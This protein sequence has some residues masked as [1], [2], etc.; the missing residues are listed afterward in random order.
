MAIELRVVDDEEGMLAALALWNGVYTPLAVSRADLADYVDYCEARFDVLALVD[1]R[2]V[3]SAFAAIEPDQ[4]ADV[5][6]SHVAVLVDARCQGAGTLLYR[7]VSGWVRGRGRTQ[8]QSIV[9]DADPDGAEW[10]RARGFVEVSRE[11]AVALQLRDAE[12]AVVP[13]DGVAIVT[14]AERPELARGMYEVVCEAMPDIPGEDDAVPAY[15]VWLRSYMGGASDRPEA[16]FVA[17]AGEEVVGFAKL[18]LSEARP[19]VAVHDLTGVRRAWR[20]RG[21]ARALKAT[22]IRWAKHN[23]YER[24]ET[25][26]ELRN[27]PIRRLNEQLGYRPIPGWARVRGPLAPA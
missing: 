7:R 10:A 27:E 9:L 8:L 11:A 12:P 5:S 15:D 3:G 26:N 2:V 18:H 6:E 16:T 25:A 17:V 13:P 1:G 22:Q 4:P 23:G 24:L 14:W 20:G 19:G 21:V